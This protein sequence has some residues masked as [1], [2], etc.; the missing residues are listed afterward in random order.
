MAFVPDVAHELGRV[1]VLEDLPDPA[2]KT[3]LV[4]ATFDRPLTSDPDQPLALHRAKHLA[5]T[6]AW[7]VDAGA[8]ITVCGNSDAAEPLL[9]ANRLDGIRQTIEGLLSRSLA[10]DVVAFRPS[11]EDPE[12]VGR[13]V[14]G[15]DL[16]VN[17]T[18][19][20]S[21]LPLPSVMLPAQGLPSSAGRTLQHDLEILGHL[22][23]KQARPFVSLLGGELSVERLSGLKGLVLRADSVLL[24]GALALPMLKALG[25]QPVDGSTDAFSW[26]CR[27]VAGLSRRIHHEIILPVDLVWRRAD[28]LTEITPAD[29]RGSGEVVDIGPS[30]R[31][32]FGDVVTGAKLTLWAGALGRVEKAAF[33]QGTRSVASRLPK[34]TPVV[35]GGDALVTALARADLVLAT[36]DMLSATD[37]A[38][39]I[40]KNGDLP[41]LAALRR[42]DSLPAS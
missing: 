35:L 13:L 19:Q 9:E 10:P 31:V 41:A 4:R 40:L 42:N 6:L 29:V 22:L 30:T 25:K 3:V 33:A 32:L 24:G 34:D 5:A 8:R 37:A 1:P 17:D 39:E 18:L 21:F 36:A 20:D 27:T 12:A 38:I 15:H 7:L 16:F 23:I 28:G 11:P 14:Q 2:G 26:E